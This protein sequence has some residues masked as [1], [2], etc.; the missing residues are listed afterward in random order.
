M[1]RRISR[2]SLWTMMTD[3]GFQL[4]AVLLLLASEFKTEAQSARLAAIELQDVNDGLWEQNHGL[5]GQLD[6]ADEQLENYADK[7]KRQQGIINKLTKDLGVLG[8]QLGEKT[9]EIEKLRPGGP[10]DI[11]AVIDTSSTSQPYIEEFKRALTGL[12][13]WTPRLSSQCRIGVLGV[14][15]KVAYEYPLTE[16]SA[17]DQDTQDALLD[18]IAGMEPATAMMNHRSGLTKAIEMLNAGNDG[19]RRQVILLVS[20]IATAEHDGAIGLSASDRRE[21][22]VLLAGIERWASKD[23]RIV[24]SI[25]TGSGREQSFDYQWFQKL[26]Q[27]GIENFSANSS[28]M[29]NVIFRVLNQ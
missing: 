12:F 14:R 7:G 10:V 11:L 18:F 16:I 6:E 1:K 13:Q 19:S 2:G 17:T 3:V 15:D 21:A 20:D 9:K 8:E 24:A 22:G 5:K 23:H 4:I 27:P 29:F 25:Y 28:E 26:A